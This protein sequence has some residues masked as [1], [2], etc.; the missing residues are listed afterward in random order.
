MKSQIVNISGFM[1]YTVS[2]TNT[3]LGHCG[4]E[5]ATDNIVMEGCGCV[6]IKLYL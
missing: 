3:Q 1:G 6:A 4:V 2:V 5:G